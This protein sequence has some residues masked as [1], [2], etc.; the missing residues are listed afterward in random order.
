MVM[1]AIHDTGQVLPQ[2]PMG[3]A[4]HDVP[5]PLQDDKHMYMSSGLRYYQQC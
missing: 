1:C 2:W 5:L 4:R 3:L